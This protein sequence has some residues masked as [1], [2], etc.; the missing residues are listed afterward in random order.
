MNGIF[1]YFLKIGTTGF[2]GPM[3]LIGMMEQH[4]VRKLQAVS[5]HDF[6][7]YVSAGKLF[8]GPIGPL[9]ATRV[10]YQVG[11]KKG[12]LL[13]GL[14][15]I[16][17]AFFMVLALAFLFSAPE[18]LSH[19]W[20]SRILN[21]LNLGGLALSAVAAVRFVKPLVSPNTLFYFI[22][23]GVL[24]FFYPRQEMFFLI[25]CGG[26]SM[27]RHRFKNTV[28][29]GSLL[30]LLFFES[31][32]ASLLT[33]GSGIA[34]IPVIRTI[35]VDQYHWVTN[36]EFLTGLTFAQITPGPFIIVNT[37]LGYR[38]AELSGALLG[39]IGILLPTFIYGI[40][41]MPLFERKLL[42][43]QGLKVFFE[44]MLPAVGGAI[45]GSMVRL[46][47]FAVVSW[48]QA[49]IFGTLIAVGLKTALHPVLLLL[50]GGMLAVSGYL[51]GIVQ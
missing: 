51:A 12:G 25:A 15:L 31:F 22:G 20:V 21:G 46:S 5:A 34:L 32:K 4:W 47:L 38:V 10:G 26:I 8:P 33:F 27:L 44:G 41:V 16:L 17:P 11:G 18:D 28:F 29:D 24:T 3:V 39:T 13:A 35:Y 6:H 23:T 2:G 36:S 45:I 9:V 14:G 49:L 30:A 19:P 48:P 1:R 37:F 43:S 42:H 7:R 40:F 50:T